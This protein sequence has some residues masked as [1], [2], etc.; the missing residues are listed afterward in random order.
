MHEQAGSRAT[1]IGVEM[2]AELVAEASPLVQGVVLALPTDDA[3][4]LDVLRGALP[5]NSL[6]PLGLHLHA[7]RY[8]EYHTSHDTT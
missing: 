5:D 4:A 6:F 1:R 7:H 8:I 2:A 3:A